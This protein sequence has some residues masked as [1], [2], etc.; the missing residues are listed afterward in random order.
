MIAKCS[1]VDDPTALSLAG[2]LLNRGEIIVIPTETIFGLTADALNPVAVK[3]LFA[4]KGRAIDKPSAVFL[5][6]ISAISRYA[7]IEHDYA[8]RIIDHFLPGP[9][10]V[11]LRSN[12]L[13]WC[14]VVSGDGKIG[15]RISSDPLVRKLADLCGKPLIATS[16]NKSGL[17]DCLS[18]AAVREQLEESVPLILY[19][20]EQS[21]TA[22]ST[23]V[24][25]TSIKP[26]MIREGA[27]SVKTLMTFS[28]EVDGV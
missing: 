12:S 10:T 9:M 5:S 24:D 22:V 3:K 18:L 14:G 15:I 20:Y 7:D 26:I 2:E 25:L 16:A 11:V 13:D 19:R 28:E 21:Q 4:V 23:V 8:R 6:D 17:P 1:H 27:I